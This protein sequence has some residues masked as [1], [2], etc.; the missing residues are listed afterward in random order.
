MQNK[1]LTVSADARRFAKLVQQGEEAWIEAGALLIKKT[2]EDPTFPKQVTQAYP[3]ITPAVIRI[4]RQIGLKQTTPTLLLGNTSPG[5]NEL[6]KRPLDEQKQWS[7]SPLPVMCEAGNKASDKIYTKVYLPVD[8]LTWTQARQVFGPD[9]VRSDDAQK[10]W[11]LNRYKGKLPAWEIVG[12]Q[13][14]FRKGTM[15]GIPEL[16]TLI[17]A[18]YRAQIAKQFVDV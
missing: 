1:S 2:E 7:A 18:C 14:Y 12:D 16:N 11:L 6:R 17:Q 13:V 4:L 10:A 5:M 8:E 3:A 15:L 9:G